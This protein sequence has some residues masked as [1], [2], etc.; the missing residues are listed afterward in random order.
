M[1]GVI[2]NCKFLGNSKFLGI[3]NRW[4]C[5]VERKRLNVRELVIH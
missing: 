5:I 3:C 1:Y 4:T 2:A